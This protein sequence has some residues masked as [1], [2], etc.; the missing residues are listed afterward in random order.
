M[1]EYPVFRIIPPSNATTSSTIPKRQPS[2]SNFLSNLSKSPSSSKE[3]PPQNMPSS[4]NEP[5]A[6]VKTTTSTTSLPASTTSTPSS[7]A[8]SLSS[9]QVPPCPDMSHILFSFTQMMESYRPFSF[10]KQA[11][12]N[13]RAA[14]SLFTYHIRHVMAPSA[15]QPALV[16]LMAAEQLYFKHG[17]MDH[18]SRRIWEARLAKVYRDLGMEEKAR[19]IFS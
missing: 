12:H 11:G 7:P 17:M 19:Q 9:K 14:R 3:L 4:L 6:A 10:T 13:S 18:S 2:W 15:S 5:Q 8:S 16:H 1:R